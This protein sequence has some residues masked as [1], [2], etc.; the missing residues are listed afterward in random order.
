MAFPNR[1]LFLERFIAYNKVRYK[2]EPK[3]VET[4]DKL[5]LSAIEFTNPREEFAPG[6]PPKHLVDM[7]VPGVLTALNQ[8]FI[9]AD[10]PDHGVADLVTPTPFAPEDLPKETVTGIYWLL[11]GEGEE[12]KG[13]VLVA[14]GSKAKETI[15]SLIQEKC[16]FDLQPSEIT[17]SDDLST[18]TIKS[19]TILGLL[20]VVES[21]GDLEEAIFNGDYIFDGTLTF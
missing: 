4:L 13:S 5:Q 7:A 10:F 20:T 11:T 8:R 21:I 1:Q 18:A 17:V 9:P 15:I 14:K 3:F 2:D 12:K 6:Q 19:S 16:I